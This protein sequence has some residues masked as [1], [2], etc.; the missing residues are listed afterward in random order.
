[1]KAYVLSRAAV[2]DLDAIWD[3][4]FDNWGQA[5][6]DRYIDDIRRACEAIG[7]GSRTGRPVDDIWPGILKLA[8]NSHFLFHRSLEDGRIGVVRILHKRMDVDARLR[9]MPLN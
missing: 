2:A 7:T 1:M 9:D 4:T 8:I 5:Q 3:Y 6:A